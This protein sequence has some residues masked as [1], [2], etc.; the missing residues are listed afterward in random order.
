MTIQINILIWTVICFCAFMLILW[1]LLLKPMLAFLDARKARIAQAHS[2]DR[3]AERAEKQALLEAQ[4][5]AEV[6]RQA[7][8]RK[9]IV[10]ALREKSRIEREERERRFLQETQARRAD[11]EAEANNLVPQLAVSLQEHVNTFTD[12]LIA[13]GER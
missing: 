6:Q 1:R 4:R 3:S 9:Q 10:L 7:E 12:K 11:V 8:E 2:L 5:L 13:F